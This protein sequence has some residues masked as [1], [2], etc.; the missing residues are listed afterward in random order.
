M[1]CF[2]ASFHSSPS[3]SEEIELELALG[4]EL[5]HALD[6][7]DFLDC[8]DFSDFAHFSTL[9]FFTRRVSGDVL[10][11]RDT[12]SKCLMFSSVG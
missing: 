6:A 11:E 8:G 2:S 7:R 1:K 3:L 4:L 9:T 10:S 5:V 12:S